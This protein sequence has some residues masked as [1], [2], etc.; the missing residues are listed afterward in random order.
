MNNNSFPGI[1]PKDDILGL[2]KLMGSK[3]PEND[4]TAKVLLDGGYDPCTKFP[5]NATF[6]T[7]NIG[8]EKGFIPDFKNGYCYMFIPN[9]GNFQDGEKIC[10]LNYDAGLVSFDTNAEVD[11]FFSLIN[12]GMI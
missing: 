3:N 9:K 6:W 1:V 2:L 7:R 12:Q 11:G 8:C 10:K 5:D 4:I